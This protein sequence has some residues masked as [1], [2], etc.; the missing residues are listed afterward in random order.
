MRCDYI[1]TF[2]DAREEVR[3]RNK[4]DV[5]TQYEVWFFGYS[6]YDASN[7][8]PYFFHDSSFLSFYARYSLSFVSQSINKRL[9]ILLDTSGLFQVRCEAENAHYT[10]SVNMPISSSVSSVLLPK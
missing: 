7:T 5:R 6:A 2:Y 3:Y 4:I 9:V 1:G 10:N 8:K